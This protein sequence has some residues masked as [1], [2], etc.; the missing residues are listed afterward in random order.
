MRR[1]SVLFLWLAI[2][3]QA[4]AQRSE[5]APENADTRAPREG[6]LSIAMP[7]TSQIVQV[8]MQKTLQHL[9]TSGVTTTHLNVV[10]NNN[11]AITGNLHI[12]GHLTLGTEPTAEN[13]ATTKLYVDNAIIGLHFK[14]ACNALADS[15]V[16]L[17]G[18]QTIDGV[19]L[20][21]GNRVLLTN[22]T[23]GV[24]N[25]IWV[26]AI[27]AWSRPIDFANGSDAAT[28]FTMI[29]GGTLYGNTSWICTNTVNHGIV[30]VDA[31][32]FAQTGAY[33]A[34]NVGTGSG[35]FKGQVGTVFQFRSFNGS[36][37]VVDTDNN[38]TVTQN[39]NDIT[40]TTNKTL[41]VSGGINFTN[42]GG[43]ETMCSID[44]SSGDIC[45]RGSVSSGQGP[46][47][48]SVSDASIKTN[49]ETLN[50][51]NCLQAIEK[52]RPV[53]FVF[54]PDW[55]K[56]SHATDKQN[57]GLIAQEVQQVL[58]N[59]VAQKTFPTGDQLYTVTYEQVIPYLIGAIQALQQEVDQLK[60]HARLRSPT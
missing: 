14:A 25:G 2:T 32:T 45:T 51:Q 53:T 52:L 19:A 39:T 3:M 28:A 11:N 34:I 16:I 60:A 6:S 44:S 49:V 8:A 24:Q 55:R 22:Q 43:G 48:C 36:G 42:G 20:V 33:T 46:G 30:G 35:T 57:A 38:I 9:Q 31:L 26:V 41:T 7:A 12:S 29:L 21:A 40:F 10:G 56:K 27:G 18:E 13:D 37:S 1:L 23:N 4:Y 54:T 47:V 15:S 59:I 58:P 50:P 17:S 5:F